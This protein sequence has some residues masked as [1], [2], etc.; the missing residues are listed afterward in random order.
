MDLLS[1]VTLTQTM[2]MAVTLTQT[3]GMATAEYMQVTQRQLNSSLLST[4]LLLLEAGGRLDTLCW[5]HTCTF[6]INQP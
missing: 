4:T 6:R 1:T 3:I 5:E 2:R